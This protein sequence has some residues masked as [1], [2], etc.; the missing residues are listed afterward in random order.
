MSIQFGVWNL[1]GSSLEPDFPRCA[2]AQTRKYAPD[3]ETFCFRQGLATFFQSFHTTKESLQE[4]QPLANSAGTLLTWDGRLDNRDELI[5]L[6]GF[7]AGAQRTDA[8]LILAG[9]ERWDTGVFQK[10]LGDWALTVWDPVKQAL[11]LA[12]D[13]VGARLLFY[14]L[15]ATRVTWST[16]L[17][18]LVLC[19]GRSP[20]LSEEFVAGYL[21]TYPAT[22]LT[23]YVGI[24]AVPPGTFVR[25]ELN[26]C[27]TQS[28]WQFDPSHR[29][30]YRADS[31]YEEHF[32]HLFASAVRRRLRVSSPVLAELSGGLD[33]TSIVCMAD[34]L[35]TDGK[36]ETPRLDTISYYD[37]DE[38]NWN[39]RPYFSL[40]E[41]KRRR[42]GCHISLG[43]TDGAFLPPED[44]LLFPLPGYD[45]SDLARSR[46]F[47]RCL[48]ASNS[49]VLLSGLGGDEFTG[50]VP[51]PI[52]ELQDLF[53]QFQW[54]RLARKLGRFS[55]QQRRP[56]VFLAFD[57]IEEFLPQ[58][59][60]R[61]YRK[62]RIAP[63][64][65]PAFVRRH[66]EVFWADTQRTRFFGPRPSFQAAISTLDH[67]RRRFTCSHPC[68]IANHRA[69][70]PY[71]D[72]DLLAF[73]FAIPREQ[74]VRPGQR[75]SLMRRS[76]VG[77]VPS[78]ILNRKR[79][80]FLARRPL[81]MLDAAK[82]DVDRLLE[83]PL[84]NACGWMDPSTLTVKLEALRAGEPEN[85]VLLTATLKLELW[86][87][88]VVHRRRIVVV[89]PPHDST[90]TAPGGRERA[91]VNL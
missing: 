34:S 41:K 37:D 79:K 70:Y 8:E 65:R 74:L 48:E 62:P 15:E 86:I 26:R 69:A 22:H 72:R 55:L 68:A 64:L 73:L 66:R 90:E 63:W 43:G 16:V 31:D 44:D 1:D 17:D 75:R 67:L 77:I 71:L 29:I 38:P 9:Y 33:S 5:Y 78:E 39:E 84:V 46:E 40:V 85:M 21:S 23:P 27:L 87:E 12:R 2:A 36:A 30:H 7:N 25:V 18:P 47:G 35:M 20:C 14:T 42:V 6:L 57:A 4:H 28:Y 91:R 52:P 76:L 19:A 10:I 13:F 81:A 11:F 53:S 3:G 83:A 61:L 45:R 89:S 50:G 82:P 60:R 51:T 58:S 88:D 32:R 49:R 59:I 56:W 80:A 54:G 24:S